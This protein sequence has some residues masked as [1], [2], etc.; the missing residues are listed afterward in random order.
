MVNCGSIIGIQLEHFFK[1]IM[2]F[3]CSC[4]EDYIHRNRILLFKFNII[5]QQIYIFPLFR[6]NIPSNSKYLTQLINIRSPWKHRIPH[7]Q[8]TQYASTRPYIQSRSIKLGSVQNF[9][10]SVMSGN[11]VCW[12]LFVRCAIEFRESKVD[13]FQFS[14]TG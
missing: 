1:Q 7:Y 5:R 12:V 2:A 13:Y 4:W 3:R 11:Y 14:F 9:R 6:I 8:F 10:C